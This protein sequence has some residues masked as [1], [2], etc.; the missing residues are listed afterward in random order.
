MELLELVALV[1]ARV[2]AEWVE[3]Q[4]AEWAVRQRA[5]WAELVELLAWVAWEDLAEVLHK[6]R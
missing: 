6:T 4:R 3:L 2:W 1:E 5:E